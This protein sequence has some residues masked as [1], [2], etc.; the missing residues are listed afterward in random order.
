VEVNGE[1]VAENLSVQ[2]GETKMMRAKKVK[3]PEQKDISWNQVTGSKED[4]S[5]CLNTRRALFLKLR[6]SATWK[7]V[8]SKLFGVWTSWG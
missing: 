8:C 2:S 5:K 7:C 4:I 3:C 1:K 6:A